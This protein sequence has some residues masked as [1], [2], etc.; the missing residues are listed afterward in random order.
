MLKFNK[1]ISVLCATIVCILMVLSP[2]IYAGY[3]Y[4]IGSNYSEG[5]FTTNVY[6]ASVSYGLKPGITSYRNYTPDY[7]YLTGNNP[8][9]QR[10]LGSTIV[11]LNGH[12]NHTVL[13]FENSGVSFTYNDGEH[14]G[15]R[16]IDMSGTSVITFAGCSTASAS[17]NLLTRSRESGARTAVG[18]TGPI[19][20]RFNDGPAWLELYNYGLSTNTTVA[21][22]ITMAVR[23]Y[24][25]TDLS[26]YVTTVGDT[27]YIVTANANLSTIQSSKLTLTPDENLAYRTNYITE[28]FEENIMIEAENQIKNA[29][30]SENENKYKSLINKIKSMDSTF[31][32]EDYKVTENLFSQQ[33]GNGVI[34]FNYYLDENIQTNKAFVATIK[35]NKI[36]EISLAGVEKKNISS[37]SN[38]SKNEIKQRVQQNEL[39]K[40]SNINIASESANEELVSYNEKYHYDYNKNELKYIVEKFVIGDNGIIIDKGYE[41]I[42]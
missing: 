38:V 18:F 21:N 34:I 35:N 13:V 9:G 3:A 33:D 42:I 22:A 5:D 40:V 41:Q 23:R 27:N 4:S 30:L 39:S 25:S 7:T 10:R 26:S 16:S 28:S 6:N 17:P 20:S 19:T 31:N 1:K 32:M 36:T 12:A 11:F 15:V 2:N 14:A 37:I 29:K 24:P 8:A